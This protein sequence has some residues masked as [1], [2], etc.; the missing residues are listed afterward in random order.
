MFIVLSSINWPWFLLEITYCKILINGYYFAQYL[1]HWQNLFW[2][3]TCQET[4]KLTH[5]QLSER[6]WFVR[7]TVCDIFEKP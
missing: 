2:F 4:H 1:I 7:T 5:K 3:A 6:F